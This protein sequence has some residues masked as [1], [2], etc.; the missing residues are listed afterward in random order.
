MTSR[1]R[2]LSTMRFDPVDRIPVAPFVLGRLDPASDIARELIRKTDPFVLGTVAG[3]CFFGAACEQEIAQEGDTTTVV[4]HTP[5][6]DLVQ[7]TRS[8]SV[9]S[10]CVEYPLKTL[11]DA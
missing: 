4:R 11:E 2:L 8:T 9:T 1:Q 7:R 10:A 6:G 5:L 3:D